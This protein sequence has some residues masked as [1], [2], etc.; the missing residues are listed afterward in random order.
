[1]ALDGGA[2]PGSGSLGGTLHRL[3]VAACLTQQALAERAGISADAVAALERGRRQHP[4]P[5]T[6]DRLARALG[7]DEHNRAELAALA[8]Q[9]AARTR[10]RAPAGPR[11][12]AAGGAL[13]SLPAPPGPLVGRDR[14]LPA[15]TQMLRRPGTRLLTLTGPGGVGKTRLALAAARQVAADHLDGVAYVPLAGISDP[16]LVAPAIT[17]AAGLPGSARRPAPEVLQAYLADRDTLLVLDSLEHLL[18]AAALAAD[19]IAACP[20][21]QILA[22][23][24]AS[25]R[26]RAE[27]QFRVPPLAVP[28]ARSQLAGIGSYPAVQLFISRAAALRG[29]PP[30]DDAD[31]ETSAAIADICRRLD[32]LPLAIELAAA[33]TDLLRPAELARRLAVGLDALGEGPRDLPSRQRTL[34]ATIEWSHSLLSE[35]ARELFARLAVF[36]GG[37]TLDAVTAVCGPGILDPLAELIQHSLVTVTDLDDERRFAMLDTIQQFARDQLAALEETDSLRRRHA[38]YL[39]RETERAGKALHSPD[40]LREL[41]KLD[42]D[43]DNIDTVLAWARDRGEWAAGLRIATAL[44]WYWIHHGGLRQGRRTLD[45][46]LTADARRTPEP[47]RARAVTAAGWLCVHQ[48]DTVQARKR[49]HDAL[50]LARACEDRW[51][52]AWAITGLGTAGVWEGT[53]DHD[54]LREQL[55]ESCARWRELGDDPGMQLALG[56]LGA[57]ELFTG[58][59]G[60]A[61]S[62]LRDC[63]DTAHRIGAPGTLALTACLQGFIARAATDVAAATRQFRFALRGAQAVGDPFVM[64]Y[65]LE[66]L[67][68]AARAEGDPA[69]AARLLGAAEGLRAIIDSPIAGGNQAGHRAEVIALQDELGTRA[70]RQARTDGRR[71]PLTEVITAALAPSPQAANA[72]QQHGPRAGA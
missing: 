49:F 14:E 9:D 31:A 47:V 6:I 15:V 67:A 19:L 11:A 51:C 65:S 12:T 22:T 7:L 71:Q 39:A 50:A 8:I 27:Q 40:Q 37:C 21:V 60:R 52:T 10:S 56:S 29:N 61:R 48:G 4:R 32:G 72:T 17:R 33:R 46:L 58:N 53:P 20:G 38:G 5:D 2:G 45:A 69:R 25:L 70:L 59:L 26:V 68:W 34:R 28:P 41:R 18:P 62:L 63:R 66:G 3:R 64:A 13:T 1:M 44:W 30:A 42:R 43:R 16:Q 54:R 23:S 24:R 55:E 57:L 36:S 35:A